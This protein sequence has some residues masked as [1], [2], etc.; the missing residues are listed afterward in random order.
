MNESDL[1]HISDDLNQL[2]RDEQATVHYDIMSDALVWSDERPRHRRARELWCMRPIFRYRT[3]LI[4]G[5]ELSEFREV[6]E[7]AK[8]LFPQWIGF[9]EDRSS[10]NVELEKEYHRLRK[11]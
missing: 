6:W 3:G 1:K 9:R 2:A 10:R 8:R 11:K 5:L 7:A 4:I